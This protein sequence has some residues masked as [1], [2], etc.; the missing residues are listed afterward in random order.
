MG[1]GP[2]KATVWKGFHAVFVFLDFYG[3][4]SVQEM[5]HKHTKDLDKFYHKN[6]KACTNCGHPFSESET[7]HLG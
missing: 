5:T 1:V 7:A 3:G 6:R 2:A 4:D